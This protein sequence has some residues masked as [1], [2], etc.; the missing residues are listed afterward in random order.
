MGLSK[1]TILLTTVLLILI[2][3]GCSSDK[4]K[5]KAVSPAEM[6][7]PVKESELNTITL[8][9]LAVKRIGIT[10]AVAG[11]GNVANSRIYSGEVMAVPGQTVTLTAPVAGTLVAAGSQLQGGQQVRKGQALYRLVILPSERDLLSARDDVAQKQVQY[12]VATQKAQR[13]DQLY[14]ERAGSLRAKQEA[15]A[16]L[17][18][19]AASLRVA[20]SRVELLRGN[21]SGSAQLSTLTINA[22]ISG[23]IQRLHSSTSQ[24]VAAAAPIADIASTNTLWVRVPVYAGD[25]DKVNRSAPASVQL[26]SGFA[27]SA[28]AITGRPIRGPQTAD[29][30]NT[31]VDLYYEISNMDENMNPGARVSISL[32]FHGSNAGMLI[33]YS[34]VVYDINGGSWVYENTAENVFVRR[35][36]EIMTV[37][38]MNAVVKRGLTGGEKIVVTGAAE[39]FGTEFGGAK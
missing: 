15:E 32:P 2:A 31:S 27:G 37:D 19:V 23:T 6:S 24:A 21:T 22:P 11:N 34:A 8:T 14:N 18:A 9:P 3:T 5:P 13:A 20:R 1:L 16:E 4:G 39:L 25:A 35:R 28:K 33:P 36:I 26:L 38:N 30:L 17:A 7:N 29:A 10:L 12:T